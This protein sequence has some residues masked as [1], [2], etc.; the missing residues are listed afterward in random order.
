MS[1]RCRDVLQQRGAALVVALVVVFLVALLAT[2]ISSDYLVLF[3]TVENQDQ[4]Q[5]AR[6][7]LRGAELVAEQALLRDMQASGDIDSTLEPW[8]QR[9]E[10][11]LPEGMLSACL[12]D[13]QGRLNLN[14]L[15]APDGALSPA[16][17]RFIRL[18][19]A[20]DEELNGAEATAL[21]N[22]VF[23]WI[24]ADDT[25]R[26]PGGAETLDY[27][28]L[29]QPYRA[30]NQAFASVAELQLVSGF[31]AARVAALTPYL[32]V[33]GNGNLNLNTLDAQ[34]ITT[35]AADAAAPV[36][37]RTLN[38]A[39][40]LLPLGSDAARMLAAARNGNGGYAEN[41]SLFSTAPFDALDWELDGIAL[42]SDWFELTAVMQS[43]SR[44]FALV[45]VLRRG[46]SAAGVPEARV[47]SRR[48]AS[49]SPQEA[50]CAA[51]LP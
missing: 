46:V 8:A 5:Q 44:R 27:L 4:L 34:L 45:S 37:L 18:L 30:A 31:D 36:M 16:Q 6:A 14:D 22:A 7:Y 2:R 12:A 48:Y 15:G 3:R 28:R 13:L 29:P 19:Q 25:Q 43:G 41:F 21:A 51:A 38:T 50:G 20:V 1:S 35:T 49:L 11:P 9:V 32:S 24:D 42:T 26:Y 47:V 10:L 40:S 39:D 33:W 23:D 17:K